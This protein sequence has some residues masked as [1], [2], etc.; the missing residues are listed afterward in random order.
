MAFRT[1]GVYKGDSFRQGA[2][3]GLSICA[4][5]VDQLHGEIHVTSA[6]GQGST[7][8]VFLPI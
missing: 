4:T 7:F 6:E 3:L 2:G 1:V 8:E 5:I